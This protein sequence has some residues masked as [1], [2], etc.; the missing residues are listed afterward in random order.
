MWK[1]LSGLDSDLIALIAFFGVVG[2]MFICGMTLEIVKALA[3][4]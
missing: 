3:P 2:S 1:F 4:K